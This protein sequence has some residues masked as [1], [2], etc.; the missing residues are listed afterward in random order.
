MKPYDWSDDA[1]KCYDLAIKASREKRIRRN[2][3]K[4]RTPAEFQQQM[5]GPVKASQ[6]D[7]VR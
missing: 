1:K 3:I 4:P 2:E 7:C 6:L 5:I